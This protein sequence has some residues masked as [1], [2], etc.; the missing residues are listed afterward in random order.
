MLSYFRPIDARIIANKW[1]EQRKSATQAVWVRS[2][3]TA[4]ETARALLHAHQYM[5]HGLSW[6]QSVKAAAAAEL[7][8][9]ATI[10]RADQQFQQAGTL[11]VPDT[12]K[13]GRGDPDHPLHLLNTDKYGPSYEAELLI[14]SRRGS[15]RTTRCLCLRRE[16]E[17]SS[18][19]P[20]T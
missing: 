2:P 4:E 14:H 19:A 17:V 6:D 9:T 8:S 18:L 15:S 10:R 11:P 5:Q 7:T 16:L 12:S 13:C 20:A 3:A 1:S